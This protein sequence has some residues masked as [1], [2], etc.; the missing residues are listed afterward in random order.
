VKFIALF[1]MGMKRINVQ[2]RKV[3]DYSIPVLIVQK[4]AK[5]GAVS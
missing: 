1:L 4:T 5:M 2:R 3:H